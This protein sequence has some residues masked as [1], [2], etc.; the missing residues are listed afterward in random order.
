MLIA[1]TY[2]ENLAKRIREIDAET[3]D[4]KFSVKFPMRSG[5]FAALAEQYAAIA[6]SERAERVEEFRAG[7]TIDRALDIIETTEAGDFT[8]EQLAC[9]V[10]FLCSKM[11]E[12]EFNCKP[13]AWANKPIGIVR[14]VDDLV[15]MLINACN[16]DG[17]HVG[18]GR[19]DDDEAR[20]DFDR[21]ESRAIN[22]EGIA[23]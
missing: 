21:A 11:N 2:R 5:S 10:D 17:N 9:L 4:L 6:D 1:S 14:T 20:A 3:R 19:G 16:R 12:R 22:S 8:D 18:D 7:N 15:I 23:A 13:V